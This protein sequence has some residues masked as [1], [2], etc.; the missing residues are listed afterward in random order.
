M[1]AP[2]TARERLGRIGLTVV[3]LGGDMQIAQVRFGSQA[4][5]LGLE[6]GFK[7][8]AIEMPAARPA[9]EWMLLPALALL[10]VVVVAQRGRLKAG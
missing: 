7:V 4:E 6:Q 5:K 3:P 8:S 10:A 9:K 1:G 2:G